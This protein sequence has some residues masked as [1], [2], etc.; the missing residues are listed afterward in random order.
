MHILIGL[1]LSAAIGLSLGLIGGGG[2]I[3]TVPVLV[4]ALGVDAHE[5]VAMSLAV[6]GVTSLVGMGLHMRQ[7]AVDLRTGLLFGGTGVVGA[8]SGS[9]LTYLVSSS[10]LLLAF[11][12][13]M[14]VA[15]TLMLIKRKSADTGR[16]HERRTLQALSAGLAVGALTGFL[17]VGGG[18]LVVPALVLFGGLEMREAAGTSLVVIALNC[19]AGL[20]GHLGHGGFDLATAGFVTGLAVLGSLVG[21]ALSHRIN[22]A[23]LQTGFAVFVFAVGAFLLAANLRALP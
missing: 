19:V 17:G 9:S 13:V 8:W 5:A 18:F 20:L 23:R 6:V 3:V 2:S 7:G 21:A 1:A 10:A 12:G 16:P 15:A 4:Y 11:S 14:L 22:P